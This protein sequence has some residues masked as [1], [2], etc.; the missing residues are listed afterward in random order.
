M[1]YHEPMRIGIMGCGPAG[2]TAALL[3]H[4]SGHEVTLT[5]RFDE[6]QVIGSGFILQPTGLAVLAELGLATSIQGL[7]Q[8][9]ERIYGL[10][11]PTDRVVLDVDYAALG[12]GFHGLAVHRAALFD[13]L[14]D[15]I[16]ARGI[17][18]TTDRKSVV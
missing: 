8:R 9:I 2:L 4:R 16:T 12:S 3:L 15:E 10:T 7:G 14:L 18:V 5:E 17:P 11:E 13:L 1:P 6:P